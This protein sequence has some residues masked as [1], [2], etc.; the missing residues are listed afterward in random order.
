MKWLSTGGLRGSKEKLGWRVEFCWQSWEMIS[1]GNE[2]K[3]SEFKVW[4]VNLTSRPELGPE[5]RVTACKIPQ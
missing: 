5:R 2:W 4:R 3:V 1:Q